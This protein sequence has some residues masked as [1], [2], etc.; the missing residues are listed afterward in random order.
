MDPTPV[1]S[2]GIHEL[3][4]AVLAFAQEPSRS[5]FRRVV[6]LLERLEPAPP[7]RPDPLGLGAR[8]GV[9]EKP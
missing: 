9:R 3:R 8:R 1:A 5:S 4:A 7:R 6:D 2:P